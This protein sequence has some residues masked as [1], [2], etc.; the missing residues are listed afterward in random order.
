MHSA[1][2]EIRMRQTER[3]ISVRSSVFLIF[4]IQQNTATDAVLARVHLLG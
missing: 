1:N 2:T 4:L 3:P